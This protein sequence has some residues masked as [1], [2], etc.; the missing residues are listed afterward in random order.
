[1][2]ANDYTIFAQ[3]P[4]G[5]SCLSKKIQDSDESISV[6]QKIEF[7]VTGKT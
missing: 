4:S 5:K 2:S 1:M 6:A 3:I 7:E